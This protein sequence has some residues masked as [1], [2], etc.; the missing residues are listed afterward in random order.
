[1]MSSFPKFDLSVVGPDRRLRDFMPR[2]LG[3]HYSFTPLNGGFL[4]WA[5]TLLHVKMVALKAICL[6]RC[7][8]EAIDQQW[9]ME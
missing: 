4:P 3:I 2:F 1:M 9:F 6:K 5:L 7:L 8:T